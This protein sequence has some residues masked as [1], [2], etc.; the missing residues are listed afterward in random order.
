MKKLLIM[1]VILF[2]VSI[3]AAYAHPFTEETV[4]SL[5]SNSPTGVTEVIVFFSY[6][7]LY[8]FHH[9]AS[10]MLLEVSV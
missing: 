5:T 3:P 7:V 10:V 1:F 8:F 4:P 2:S 6:F 9:T